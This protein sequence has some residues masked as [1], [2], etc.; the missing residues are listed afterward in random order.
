MHKPRASSRARRRRRR[1]THT[2]TPWIRVRPDGV[3]EEGH[4]FT[5]LVRTRKRREAPP[6]LLDPLRVRY[7]LEK[8]LHLMLS[9][10]KGPVW[11]DVPLHHLLEGLSQGADGVASVVSGCRD[12]LGHL[13]DQCRQAHQG[14]AD[15]R[16][17]T[18]CAVFEAMMQTNDQ[19]RKRL[20]VALKPS[21]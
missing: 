10:R 17:E 9:G 15:T 7:E 18:A 16:Q 19:V 2:H 14:Q 5:T 20:E 3:H 13:E 12:A 21:V 11:L 6:R 8:A 4:S 1:R